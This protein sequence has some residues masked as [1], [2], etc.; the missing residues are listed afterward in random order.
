VAY[1]PHQNMLPVNPL[2][3]E[4]PSEQ[5]HPNQEANEEPREARHTLHARNIRRNTEMRGAN[6]NPSSLP[7]AW[8]HC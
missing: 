2:D 7:L 6:T 8:L 5:L 4:R 1:I 3:I